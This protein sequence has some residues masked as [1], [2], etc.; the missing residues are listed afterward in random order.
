MTTTTSTI[1]TP[2]QQVRPLPKRRRPRV[3]HW[4]ANSEA[5]VARELGVEVRTHCGT[6]WVWPDE[7]SDPALGG[8]EGGRDCRNCM[9]VMWGQLRREA[10]EL[11]PP[12]VAFADDFPLGRNLLP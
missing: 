8:G 12:G 2:E 3:R 5:D 1:T 6:V 4:V 11:F 10:P 9:R 7:L